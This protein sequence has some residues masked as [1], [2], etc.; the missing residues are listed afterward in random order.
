MEYSDAK[1]VYLKQKE[2]G[3][4]LGK[5]RLSVFLHLKKNAE[6]YPTFG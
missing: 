1:H 3:K 6:K 2:S 5:K 4:I